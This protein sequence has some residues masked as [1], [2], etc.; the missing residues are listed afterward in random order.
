MRRRAIALVGVVVTVAAVAWFVATQAPDQT[1]T[2]PM[3]FSPRYDNARTLDD[4]ARLEIVTLQRG[5][6]EFAFGLRSYRNAEGLTAEAWVRKTWDAGGLLDVSPLAL[7]VAS[8]VRVVSADR[9]LDANEGET[10][11]P[12]IAVLVVRDRVVV[13]DRLNN[14]ELNNATALE[15]LARARAD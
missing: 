12:V 9:W 8:G 7:Q 1:L 10:D 5:A 2:F 15:L 13:V 4:G 11:F 6:E 3:E 14:V